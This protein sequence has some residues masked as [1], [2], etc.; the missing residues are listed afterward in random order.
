MRVREKNPSFH[1][2]FPSL[3]LAVDVDSNYRGE[4][5]PDRTPKC[6]GALCLTSSRFFMSVIVVHLIRIFDSLLTVFRMGW[7]QTWHFRNFGQLVMVQRRMAVPTPGMI[8]LSGGIALMKLL[9]FVLFG[10]LLPSMCFTQINAAG[11]GDVDRGEFPQLSVFSPF[12]HLMESS[13]EKSSRT[14]SPFA[15][16][17]FLYYQNSS[18]ATYTYHT[19]S[20]PT[21]DWATRV[22]IPVNPVQPVTQCTV[23][24]V[25]LDFELLNA[26]PLDK[27]TIRIFIR[28][29]FNPYADVFN[30]FF[31]ARAG[32]NHGF[33]E[34]DPPNPPHPYVTVTHT[35]HDFLIGYR[36]T[37][38]SAHQ[39]K[40][41]FTT[42]SLNTI[43]PRSYQFA[44]RTSIVPASTAV[45][46]SVDQVFEARICTNYIPVELS[47]FNAQ[48]EGDAVQLFW[49]T[50][51]ETNNFHFEVQRAKSLQGP[52][53]SRTFLPGHGTT[54]LP[55]EYR[56]R[57][58]YTLSDFVP[59]ETPVYWYRLI[60]RD[61]DGTTND[62]AP[63]QIHL[64]DLA[65]L[66]FELGDVYPNPMSLSVHDHASIRYRIAEDANVR[67]SVH[68]M[69]GR[70]RAVLVDHF[71]P[72]GVFESA[73]S[74]DRGSGS[75]RS[76]QYFVRMQA[77]AFHAVRKLSIVG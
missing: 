1:R 15:C 23:W 66:G 43:S 22:S 39:V 55:Q 27:D 71:Q 16:P 10:L 18:S 59:G 12:G 34:I 47:A 2:G 24:T 40:F 75:I 30:I 50:E 68:D 28:E 17:Y 61:Y 9:T 20:V 35:R 31:L 64:A 49:R 26:S 74:P 7:I 77:G 52:W 54:A 65:V 63:I 33:F 5:N 3:L 21:H 38:D 11:S 73:W 19:E 69:L 48:V 58:P 76:G 8:R 56:F 44:T 13:M 62:F 4:S 72:A 45:G 36:V 14:A 42:P 25:K 6:R 70:E 29:A 67:I 41:K 57:D 32:L 53:E 46:T 37:G 51:T 60:Q